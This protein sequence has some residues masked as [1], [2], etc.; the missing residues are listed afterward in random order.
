MLGLRD[1][2]YK[3][4]Y[5]V[6]TSL[7]ELFDLETDRAET[8]NLATA[9]PERSREYRRRLGGWVTY[10]REFLARHGVR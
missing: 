1:G 8:H 10:Q 9:E 3:Y 5:Y 7:E 4:H 6:D 2:R